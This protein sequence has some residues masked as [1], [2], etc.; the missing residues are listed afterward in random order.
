MADGAVGVGQSIR[1]KV[2]LLDRGA[3]ENKNGAQESAQHMSALF[4]HSILPHT[5]WHRYHYYTPKL[6]AGTMMTK[7][8]KAKSDQFAFGFYR[9]L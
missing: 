3:E 4:G 8:I 7:E 5:T 6:F 9:E 2:C 1:V